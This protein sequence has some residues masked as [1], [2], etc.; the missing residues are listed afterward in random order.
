MSTRKIEL[1]VGAVKYVD[2]NEIITEAEYNYIKN[3]VPELNGR[4]GVIEDNIDEINSSL[5]K[6]ANKE[7]YISINKID[8][9]LG[10][11]DQTYL[12]DELLQQIAGNAP[13]NSV[14]S[15]SSIVNDKLTPRCVYAY[16]TN[17]IEGSN[18]EW[19]D[20]YVLGELTDSEILI[21]KSVKTTLHMVE[22]ENAIGTWK[23]ISVERVVM[24]DSAGKILGAFYLATEEEEHIVNIDA[25]NITYYNLFKEAKYISVSTS[26]TKKSVCKILY[27]DKEVTLG[28]EIPKLRLTDNQLKQCDNNTTAYLINNLGYREISNNHIGYCYPSNSLNVMVPFEDYFTTDFIKAK[29]NDVITIPYNSG[30]TR[31][32]VFDLNKK[33]LGGWTLNSTTTSNIVDDTFKLTIDHPLFTSCDFIAISARLSEYDTYYVL[34]NDIDKFDRSDFFIF[35]KL[36]KE[37]TTGENLNITGENLNITEIL[38]KGGNIRLGK[39]TFVLDN[40]ILPPNTNIDGQGE[41]TLIKFNDSCT[42]N[43]I[44]LANSCKISNVVISG[45]VTTHPTTST[46]KGDRTAISLSNVI[47]CKIENVRVTGFSAYGLY[48]TNV[49]YNQEHHKNLKV[50]NCDFEYNYIGI[51]YDRRAEY[52][53][54]IN[55]ACGNNFL[56]C[57]NR[58]G[59]NLFS[60]CMFNSNVHGFMVQGGGNYDNHGH[61][62]ASNC[63]FNHNTESGIIAKDVTIGYIFNG[64]QHFDGDLVLENSEGIW[65]TNGELGSFKVVVKGGRFNLIKDNFFYTKPSKDITDGMT[66]FENNR[67]ADGTIFSI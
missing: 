66:S 1:S 39:G 48:V 32:N 11:I 58:G 47:R 24:F 34:I 55:T 35:D 38:E 19:F 29:F 53:Q 41:D 21:E 60:N 12:T 57:V 33:Y 27:N 42:G 10:K 67:L 50:T 61:S 45:G 28:Y 65:F 8:K 3:K 14:P 40:V 22:I 30:Y 56:G 15:N 36:K 4:V 54:T 2:P 64:C 37:L 13:V 46:I 16:N 43:M 51:L 31:V 49:G 23:F 20:G 26:L 59:N 5:D 7:D 63:S 9:N 52:I 44:T 62:S 17:F 18:G 6:K 25:T